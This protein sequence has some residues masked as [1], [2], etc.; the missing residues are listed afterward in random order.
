MQ[1]TASISVLDT[2]RAMRDKVFAQAT[3]WCPEL[4]KGVH[5][6]EH[7]PILQLHARVPEPF[8]AVGRAPAI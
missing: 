4:C 5:P 3:D 6:A 1:K 7:L 8:L 2:F